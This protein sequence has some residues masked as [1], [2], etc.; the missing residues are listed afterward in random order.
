MGFYAN[1]TLHTKWILWSRISISM[2]SICCSWPWPWMSSSYRAPLFFPYAHFK[3]ILWSPF[4]I[5]CRLFIAAFSHWHNQFCF[6]TNIS[7]AATDSN[8]SNKNNN[9][10]S[11]RCNNSNSKQKT[12]NKFG[13]KQKAKK[14]N[15]NKLEQ[16]LINETAQYGSLHKQQQQISGALI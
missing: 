2:W 12:L 1:F 11:D 3:M 15:K 7:T 13:K 14:R 6:I 8:S 9:S 10:S 4:V 5:Y 16:R